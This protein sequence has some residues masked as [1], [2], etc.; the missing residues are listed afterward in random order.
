MKKKLLII[1]FLPFVA[2]LLVGCDK[3][4]TPDIE[5][6]NKESLVQTIFADQTIGQSDI[7]FT[8]SGAWTTKITNENSTAGTISWMSITPEYGDKGGTH[9]ISITLEENLSGQD[10]IAKIYI[11][12]KGS[13]IMVQITQKRTKLFEDDIIGVDEKSLN[14]V[15]FADQTTGER[16]IVFTSTGAWTSNITAENSSSENIDW[17]NISPKS[18]E[19]AGNYAVSISLTENFTNIERTANIFIIGQNNQVTATITQK[20]TKYSDNFFNVT[21]TVENGNSYNYIIGEV[22]AIIDYDY[23]EFTLANCNYANG[24]FTIDLPI[25][26]DNKFLRRFFEDNDEDIDWITASDYDV[27][28]EELWFEGY[29]SGRWVGDFYLEKEIEHY[30]PNSEYELY[31]DGIYFYSDRDV[32]I[33]GSYS[34]NYIYEDQGYI[35]E[36]EVSILVDLTL[37][38]GWNILYLIDEDTFEVVDN[39]IYSSWSMTMTTS[40]PGQ[41]KWYFYDY[42]SWK[43]AKKSTSKITSQKF[44]NN[45]RTADKSKI[46]S[47]IK[48]SDKK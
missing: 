31:V 8:T 34:E 43:S 38:K 14:Q 42:S 39:Y 44:F 36:N 12:C 6:K 5:I 40:D 23:D 2:A 47:K 17:I 37:V 24:G 16:D 32:S 48:P 4:N 20:A 30:T 46:I 45:K 18:G 25:N 27:M 13:E 29:K 26:V 11:S 9:T 10:R 35:I 15:V 3:N 19:K 21:V 28:V 41:L 7:I 1:L 22:R 33:E